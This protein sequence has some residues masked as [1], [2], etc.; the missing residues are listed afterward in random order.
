[1]VGEERPREMHYLTYFNYKRAKQHLRKSQS[2]AFEQ[3]IKNSQADIGNAAGCDARLFWLIIYKQTETP[4][5]Q[6]PEI[7]YGGITTITPDTLSKVFAT[8]FADI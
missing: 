5:N 3:Y 1:M 6:D 2:L 8:Y 4:A 7:V